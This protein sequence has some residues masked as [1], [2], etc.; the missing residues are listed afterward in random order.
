MLNEEQANKIMAD[1]VWFSTD[2]EIW[3]HMLDHLTDLYKLR[4][5]QIYHN[6]LSDCGTNM[7]NRDQVWSMNY[8]T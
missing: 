6:V 4:D 8:G 1:I 2:K 5:N 7:V 3:G